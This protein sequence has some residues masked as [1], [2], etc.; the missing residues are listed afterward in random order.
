MLRVAVACKDMRR[1][2]IKLCAL[3]GIRS[4]I[5]AVGVEGHASDINST[6]SQDVSMRQQ[7][8]ARINSIPSPIVGFILYVQRGCC[9]ATGADV[10]ALDCRR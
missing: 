3:R 6:V 4:V 10:P 5:A 7:A 8:D 9:R 2:L 1:T